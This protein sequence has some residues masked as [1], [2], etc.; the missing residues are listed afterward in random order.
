MKILVTG[1]D[2][3][4]GSIICWS[5]IKSGDQVLGTALNPRF[6]IKG[7]RMEKLDITNR[8]ACLA[9]ARNWVPDA[10]VHCAR[11]AV[12][13]GQCERYRETAFRINAIAL[14]GGVE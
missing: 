7:C 1:N 11:Y 12:G 9:S 2:G 14:P 13:L 3:F 6:P 4:V 8:E 10:I 5:A